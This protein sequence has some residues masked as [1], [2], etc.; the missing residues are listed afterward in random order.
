MACSKPVDNQLVVV[1]AR[2]RGSNQVGQSAATSGSPIK[3]KARIKSS[4]VDAAMQVDRL[5]KGS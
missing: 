5:R 1:K 2:E 3:D 4:M